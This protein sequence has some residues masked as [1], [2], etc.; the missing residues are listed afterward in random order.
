MKKQKRFLLKNILLSSIGTIFLANSGLVN[1]QTSTA[2]VAA[3]SS[4]VAVVKPEI[5]TGRILDKIQKTNKIVIGNRNSSIPISFYDANKKPI[6]YGIDICVDFINKLKVERNLPNLQIEFLEVSGSTRIPLVMAG[7]VDIECG[8][9]TNNASRRKDVSFSIPYYIAGV[10]ILAKT[11]SGITSLKDLKNK[12]VV[13]GKGTSTIKTLNSIKDDLS[14]SFKITEAVDF[15][16]ALQNVVKGTADAFVLD[17]LLLFGER[18]KL[19][20]PQDYA[21]VG[22]FLSIE[23][24]AIMVRNNDPEFKNLVDKYMLDIINSG[25]IN[26]Y[27]SKWFESPIPPN[28][29][30]LNIPQ[31]PLLKDL[32]RMPTSS[33]GN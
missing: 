3:A 24:L 7:K 29:K 9:T 2:P 16:T 8:S 10:R 14:M 32:F 22:E 28:N 6:G 5:F 21:V 20:N 1:A 33:V 17:D 30:A 26:E 12:T 15:P 13:V 19:D 27:Y 31:T 11:N 18:A 23:P 25:K 4:Q